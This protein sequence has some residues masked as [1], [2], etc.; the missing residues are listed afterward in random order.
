MFAAKYDAFQSRP[1][2]KY[3]WMELDSKMEQLEFD[4]EYQGDPMNGIFKE[5][6]RVSGDNPHAVGIISIIPSDT[7]SP[8]YS[9]IIL[10]GWKQH[11]FSFQP[12]PSIYFDFKERK[13]ILSGYSFQT[14]AGDKDY[15]HLKSW[16]IQG[17]ND[18]FDWVDI[19]TK[20][21][22]FELNSSNAVKYWKVE[23]KCAYRC[24]RILLTGPNHAGSDILVLKHVEFFGS[25]KQNQ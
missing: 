15:G 20:N 14:Y 18:A 8:N 6:N 16:K 13:I 17:S 21:D 1:V 25:I 9:N 22:N 4:V 7:T 3:I 23:N 24:I 19:D 12:N 2:L 10:N 5:L 11:W